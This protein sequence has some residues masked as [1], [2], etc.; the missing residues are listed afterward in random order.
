MTCT[1]PAGT[2]PTIPCMYRGRPPRIVDS[3]ARSVMP[4]SAVTCASA[5]CSVLRL[6]QLYAAGQGA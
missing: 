5:W 2:H 6:A 4:G 1:L 3:Y